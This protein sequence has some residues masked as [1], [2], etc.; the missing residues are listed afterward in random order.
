[1]QKLEIIIPDTLQDER[2]SE[3]PQVR[4]EP[5]IRF[6]A[7]VPLLLE[8]GRCFGAFCIADTRPRAMNSA[9]MAL[10]HDLGDLALRELKKPSRAKA[11]SR[12]RR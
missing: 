8:D 11:S 3:D 10:L 5:P 9:D 12:R 1:M 7:G 6:Y 4:E 2:F